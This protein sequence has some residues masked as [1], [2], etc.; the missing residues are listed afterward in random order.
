VKAHHPLL[1]DGRRRGVDASGPVVV[2][3]RHLAGFGVFQD[4]VQLGGRSDVVAQC[5]W[6]SSGGATPG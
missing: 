3:V 5:V 6:N 2:D 4:R 1:L